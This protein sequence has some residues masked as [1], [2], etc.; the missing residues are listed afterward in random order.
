M[1]ETGILRPKQRNGNEILEQKEKSERSAQKSMFSVTE[2]G[3][4]K[5]EEE[6]D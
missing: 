1:F 4:E 3:R 2:Q 5:V 6:K